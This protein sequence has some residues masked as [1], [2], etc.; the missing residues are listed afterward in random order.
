MCR[1]RHTREDRQTHRH[2]RRNISH[3]DLD[4]SNNHVVMLHRLRDQLE[5]VMCLVGL[6]NQITNICL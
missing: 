3:L 6:H 5:H 2:A 1:F 4:R